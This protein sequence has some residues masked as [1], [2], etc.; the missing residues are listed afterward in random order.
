M[1]EWVEKREQTAKRKAEK[2]TKTALPL[3]I[4]EE[5][6]WQ[7]MAL[8]GGLPINLFAEWDGEILNPL[9]LNQANTDI[10]RI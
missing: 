2:A 1:A 3:N 4:N 10:E 6:S 8:S 5:R 7:L 9:S